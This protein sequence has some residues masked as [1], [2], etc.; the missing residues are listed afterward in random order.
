MTR[1]D[2]SG[3]STAET[4]RRFPVWLAGVI[5]ILVVGIAAIVVVMVVLPRLRGNEARII[6]VV[7]PGALGFDSKPFDPNAELAPAEE[8][9]FDE[10]TDTAS[11]GAS[12]GAT[13]EAPHATVSEPQLTPQAAKDV[14]GLMLQYMHDGRREEALALATPQMLKDVNNDKT[15][16][17]PGPDVFISFEIKDAV[18][19]DGVLKV[20]VIEDWNSGPEKTRYSVILKDGK[21][22]VDG[23]EWGDV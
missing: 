22:M 18:E 4:K 10:P 17:S 8:S 15:W 6:A 12:P 19:E 1:D 11:A 2:D 14:V 21:P 13:P 16:F 23:I 3:T 7:D 5:A 9:A 20:Y